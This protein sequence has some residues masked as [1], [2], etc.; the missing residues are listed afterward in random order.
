MDQRAAAEPPELDLDAGP[1]EEPPVASGMPVPPRP[2]RARD[3]L[4]NERTL[5]AWV[6]TA[7]TFMALGFGVARFGIFLRE[8]GQGASGDHHYSTVIGI[9]LVVAGLASG[10]AA[11]VRFVRVRAQIER[12]DFIAE[13][14]AEA[15]LVGMVVAIGVA[16]IVYLAL[17]S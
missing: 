9:A 15:L 1:A 10:V 7:I 17:T 14:W 2:A 6:R 5:L 16:L 12:G 3:H 11:A 8:V 4:A 13:W